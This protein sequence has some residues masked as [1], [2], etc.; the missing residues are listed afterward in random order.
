M[1]EIELA[2]LCF[3]V[4]AASTVATTVVIRVRIRRWKEA[5]ERLAE[6]YRNVPPELEIEQNEEKA[7]DLAEKAETAQKLIKRL[8]LDLKQIEPIAD[9]VRNGSSPPVFGYTDSSMLKGGVWRHRREQ[10][11][12]MRNDEVFWTYGDFTLFGNKKNGAAL[13]DDYKRVMLR[14]FDAEFEIL[15]KKLTRRNEETSTHKLRTA[16]EQLNTMGEAV[17][18]SIS[19]TY[20]SSKERELAEYWME[21]ERDFDDREERREQQ[22]LLREQAKTLKKDDEQLESEIEV[23][24]S[25]LKKAKQR[26]AELAGISDDDAA[27]ELLALTEEIAKHEQQIESSMAEAQK[28]KAGYIYVISNEGSFGKGVVKIG[29]TRRLEP[30]D[31]VVELGDASVPYRFDVHTLAFVDDAPKTERQ[32][33]QIFAE[34]RVNRENNRKEFFAASVD[35]VQ[36]AME[37]LGVESEWYEVAEA[38]EYLQSELLRSSIEQTQATV[39]EEQYPE[40][41]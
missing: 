35:D 29:M 16:A 36:E 20:L 3:S 13:V 10:L 17:N 23:S 2:V 19:D 4:L 15:R 31:R 40:E 5:T 9:L 8:Q 18:V 22:K 32:L 33:H 1:T 26:A 28:T 6:L 14:S 41:I 39:E 7:S 38:Q 25:L 27:K 24:S 11:A 30:M 12:M 34:K 37:S 21:L